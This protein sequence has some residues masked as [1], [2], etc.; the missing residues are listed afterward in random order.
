MV[1]RLAVA[2]LMQLARGFPV[3]AITGPRQSGKTTLARGAFP[4][5]PYVNLEDPDTRELALADPRRFLARHGAGAILDEVQRA[6]ALLSYLLAVVD[7]SPRMGR[8]VLTGSQQFGLMDGINQSLAGRVGMLTLLPLAQ[9]ELGHPAVALEERLWRGGYPAL[10]ARHRQPEPA[11]WFAAYL[12][13]Y[14]ERDVRQLLNVSN[15]MTFQR[16]L[17]MCAARSG[18]LLNLN[19]LASDCGISQPTARQWL[20]VLQA[21]YIVTLVPPYHRNFGKRLVKAPKLYMLDSGLLCHLLRIATP[22]DL[23]VHAARG[24][25]FETWVVAETL[26]HRYNLGL[27]ADL[28]F[29]R[30]NHGL[31]VDLVFEHE[32]R[33]HGVECKSG[34]TYAADWLAP[35]RRWRQ[36]VGTEAAPPVL[37]YGGDDSHDR[38]DHRVLS[39]RDIGRPSLP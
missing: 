36:A 29:W 13:T 23:Q 9:A 38:A 19:S 3:L 2:T 30:D 17:A 1:A 12:A 18:Q 4:D 32:G 34:T 22:A 39:W 15:L 20:T 5:L 35:A 28:Y 37:V 6:P 33:L 31:E 24:A 7:A 11:H 21:S 27:R 16:F 14:V 10:Y 25:V 8:F 26:K